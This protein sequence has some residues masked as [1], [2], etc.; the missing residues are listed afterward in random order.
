MS[1]E[2]IKYQG[3]DV[4]VSVDTDGTYGKVCSECGIFEEY[5]EFTTRKVDGKWYL[6][7][8]CKVTANTRLR[9]D[10]DKDTVQAKVWNLKSRA[11]RIGLPFNITKEDLTVPTY[12]PILGLKLEDT[13]GKRRT[14]NTWSVDRIIPELGYVKGNVVVVSWRA[15]RLKND[16]TLEE[17][18][19]IYK[20]Y[21]GEL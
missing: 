13:R 12:C 7:S 6:S 1:K 9:E 19:K 5:T 11:N 4:A 10:R 3:R 2:V 21:K 17:L 20:F 15:N 14:D 16:A 8:S 18:E